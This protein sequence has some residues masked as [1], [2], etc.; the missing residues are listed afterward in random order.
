M[1]GYGRRLGT[2]TVC[3]LCWVALVLAPF[4][5][6]ALAEASGDDAEVGVTAGAPDAVEKDAQEV[7]SSTDVQIGEEGEASVEVVTGEYLEPDAEAEVLPAEEELP[8]SEPTAAAEGSVGAGEGVDPDSDSAAD[9]GADAP[10]DSQDKEMSSPDPELESDLGSSE[11]SVL[12]LDE[13]PLLAQK[14]S[15]R[16]PYFV[17]HNALRQARTGTGAFETRCEYSDRDEWLSS[18]SYSLFDIDANGIPEI[19]VTSGTRHFTYGSEFFTVG[20]DGQCVHVGLVNDLKLYAGKPGFLYG[21][22]MWQGYTT[23]VRIQMVKGQITT[24]EL[25]SG[26]DTDYKIA[27]AHL[28]SVGAKELKS[29]GATDFSLIEPFDD[30]RTYPDVPVT[31]W[32][33]QVIERSTWLGL[34]MGY[35]DGR[36]GKDDSITRG[37]VAVVLWRMAGQ[38]SVGAGAKNFPDV[39]SGTY[40]YH[41]VRWASSVGV[42]SGYTNGKFGP[43]DKVTRQQLAVMIANYAERVRGLTV[44]GS[45]SD[46]AEMKD[47]NKVSSY[48]V[49]AVAW[50]YKKRIISGSNGRILPTGNATRAQAAKMLVG[51]YDQV[52]W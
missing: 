37:Q 31:H 43:N 40:Y 33:Y 9:A 47:A 25:W 39:K 2:L 26:L 4:P 14:I 42:V 30:G 1:L 19:I 28:D 36:F 27:Y 17:Y 35:D 41:A 13:E 22:Q 10:L 44:T 20:T 52:I 50:C 23:V 38:P 32:A 5:T 16:A 34:L 45:R 18:I 48:A 8:A 29:A 49:R 21:M 24:T 51:L 46:F 3:I 12:A 11:D 7:E 15:G 6:T